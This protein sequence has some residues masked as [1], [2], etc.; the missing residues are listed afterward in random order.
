MMSCDNAASTCTSLTPPTNGI[1]S[2]SPD[3]TPPFNYQTM[4]TYSCNPGYG[5][6]VGDSVRTCISSSAGAGEWTGTAP[7]CSSMFDIS[8][9]SELLLKPCLII[10]HSSR[11]THEP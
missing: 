3:N 7:I 5:L 8:I 11:T 10:S 4:A 2:Y 6:S 9:Y 1:I